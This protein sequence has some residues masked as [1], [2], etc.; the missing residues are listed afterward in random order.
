MSD[1]STYSPKGKR[2]GRLPKY[3]VEEAYELWTVHNNYSKVARLLSEKYQTSISS[4]AVRKR[5]IL[6]YGVKVQERNYDNP[7]TSGERS[8]RWYHRQK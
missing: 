8:R 6:E 4:E 1:L 2:K 7:M 5:L 3:P